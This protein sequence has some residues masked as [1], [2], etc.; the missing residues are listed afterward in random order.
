M[1]D[2]EYAAAE[3]YAAW[4]KSMRVSIVMIAAI[5][6]MAVVGIALAATAQAWWVVFAPM[7]VAICCAAVVARQSSVVSMAADKWV[8][9][10]KSSIS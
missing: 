4:K 10:V 7:A 2:R 6:V 8:R 3:Y 1:T 5:W 9:A